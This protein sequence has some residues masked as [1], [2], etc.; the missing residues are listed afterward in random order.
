MLITVLKPMGSLFDEL[1]GYLDW[2]V[3]LRV[4]REVGEFIPVSNLLFPQCRFPNGSVAHRGETVVKE[5]VVG[6]GVSG[7]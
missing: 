2:G 1:L 4:E 7:F 5:G 3:L 6:G